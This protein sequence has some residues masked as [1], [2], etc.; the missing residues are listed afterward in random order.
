M[1]VNRS[2]NAIWSSDPELDISVG[3]Y[4]NFFDWKAHVD[5][6]VR[7]QVERHTPAGQPAPAY[8]S[9]GMLARR[10]A[11]Q[12][13]GLFQEDRPHAYNLDW[14]VRA[15][16]AGMREELLPEVVY[17]RRIHGDNLSIRQSQASYADFAQTLR[18]RILRKRQG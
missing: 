12:R 7:A 3:H 5:P 6:Q 14:F 17:R 8:I 15:R 18:D 1:R 10:E 4:V 11:F 13:V 16:E 2:L 9:V